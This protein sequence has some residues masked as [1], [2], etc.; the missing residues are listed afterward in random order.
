[1]TCSDPPSSPLGES[2]LA[3]VAGLNAHSR[4]APA[5][6]V[7]AA[8][9]DTTALSAKIYILST[10]MIT[11]DTTPFLTG[12]PTWV[13][14]ALALDYV[15]KAALSETTPLETV[16]TNT[17]WISNSFNRILDSNRELF[18]TNY[19]WKYDEPM[20]LQGYRNTAFRIAPDINMMAP[21]VTDT[22]SLKEIDEKVGL[23]NRIT[24]F[25][26]FYRA[27][28]DAGSR[29]LPFESL[30]VPELRI[31]FGPFHSIKDSNDTEA[32]Y[33]INARHTHHFGHSNKTDDCACSHS[34]SC[35]HCDPGPG[36]S[37]LCG[38]MVVLHDQAF[39][40][41]YYT[42]LIITGKKM[43]PI[44]HCFYGCPWSFKISTEVAANLN[45]SGYTQ[46]SSEDDTCTSPEYSD[47]E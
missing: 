37:G 31:A 23:P 26:T 6:A 41:S 12:Q 44:A 45:L 30:P 43:R 19:F 7:A 21:T 46:G 2:T 36:F 13:Q 18:Q 40:T 35:V 11:A 8:R 33:C 38:C 27:L 14:P 24:S 17:W 42:G 22:D 9:S 16:S 4:V 1:L 20:G 32:L 5:S 39:E 28:Y 29:T 25:Q 34:T 3:N 10:M 47:A 15:I